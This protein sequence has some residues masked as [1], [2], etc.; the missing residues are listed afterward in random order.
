MH[1]SS[2]TQGG[3]GAARRDR[4]RTGE[5][6]VDLCRRGDWEAGIPLLVQA[7]SEVGD[8]RSLPSLFYSYLGY[9]IARVERRTQEGLKLCR[10]AIKIE[11]YQP[12]NYLNLARTQLLAGDRGPAVRTLRDGLRI[13]PR[14]EEMLAL[15]K[16]LGIRQSPVLS[17][18][19]RDNPL[20]RALG[21]L[22]HQL[23]RH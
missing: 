18:L 10:H 7:A 5:R 23:T 15:A 4:T 6:G 20:N 9:G 3:P 13:D 1:P 2:V 22:R 16:E 11:F 21:W 17:F 8:G 19:S 14:H 12:E